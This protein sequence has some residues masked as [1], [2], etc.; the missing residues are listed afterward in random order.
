MQTSA[1][2]RPFRSALIWGLC[3][4]AV[5]AAVS[6]LSRPLFPVDETRYLTV[7][8]QMHVNDDYIL[9]T[10][11][12][13]LYHHKPPLMF[14]SINLMWALFGISRFAASLVPVLFAFGALTASA[15]LAK[16][17]WP[18]RRRSI[19]PLTILLGAGSLPF[20]VYGTLFLFDYMLA[21]C[22]ALA[23]AG[24]RSSGGRGSTRG[25][26][27]SPGSSGC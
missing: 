7:A 2:D 8:W 5:F 11:N 3:L 23:M 16:T 25:V 27:I 20:L 10:L 9:P 21:L 26:G 12:F 6:V 1:Q 19:A 13:E 14:W 24:P 15:L 4:W 22:V 18:E 17:L